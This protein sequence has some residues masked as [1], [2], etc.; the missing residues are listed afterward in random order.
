MQSILNRS[1]RTKEKRIRDERAKGKE[2][3]NRKKHSDGR[4]KVSY[5]YC[6]RYGNK[7]NRDQDEMAQGA[8]QRMVKTLGKVKTVMV[9][10]VYRFTM[11]TGD[12]R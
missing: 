5:K 11:R 7:R 9:S 12:A 4:L 10:S 2:E 8:V 6:R 1:R 3:R